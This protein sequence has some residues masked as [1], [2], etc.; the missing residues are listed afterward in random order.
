M[1]KL[2]RNSFDKSFVDGT[3]LEDVFVLGEFFSIHYF[4]YAK[5]F[6]FHGECHDFWEMVY[7]DKGEAIANADGKD[8]LLSHG[9]IIFHKPGEW[10]NIQSELPANSVIVTFECDSPA[11][12][13]FENKVMKVGN[14]QKK[15][16]SK[17]I[18][19]R[20]NTF[21]GPLNDLY[22]I[23]LKKRENAPFGSQQ[24]IKQYVAELLI[25]LT[26]NDDTM[27]TSTLK[28]HI[29]DTTFYEIEAYM[30]KNIH[31]TVTLRE[32]ASF[33][34]ISISSLR[35]IF[36]TTV[37]SGVIE[38]FINLKIERAKKYIRDDNY[39]ITQISELLG[40]SGTHY[41]SRQFHQKTGMSPLQYSKSI[42][43]ML[44]ETL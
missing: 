9:D 14:I 13:F 21:E 6:S 43:S 22:S 31:R 8:I 12:N 5:G 44:K 39:N 36:H 10:H 26:R 27:Q 38:Y 4:E 18:A 34:N 41:F 2:E 1:K 20:I 25:L 42:K 15:L 19:E 28:S 29:T 40:Y 17:I 3:P 23:G 32:L 35:E 33:A 24:L 37:S 30:L 11:M 7:I 16:I